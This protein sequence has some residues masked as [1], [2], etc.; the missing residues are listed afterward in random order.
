[1]VLPHYWT[2]D[3]GFFVFDLN[4]GFLSRQ[5]EMHRIPNTWP[6]NVDVYG[7]YGVF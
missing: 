3:A 1:M 6:L 4:I 2:P 5:L 7:I